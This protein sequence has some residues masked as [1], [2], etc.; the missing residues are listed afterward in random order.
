MD[1]LPTICAHN[2]GFPRIGRSRE[3]KWALEAYW[4]GE[5]DRDELERRGRALR[6]R[7]WEL[8]RAAGLD[9]VPVGDF[10]WYDQVL[11]LTA[12]LGVIP[13]R[14]GWDGGAVD[15]D[16][17]FRLARGQKA[18]RGNIHPL[19]ML[20]WFNTN[21]HY[22]VPEFNSQTSFSLRDRRTKSGN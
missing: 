4:R 3:L 10:S 11:D 20:K 15:L 12:L 18:S 6:R 19:S 16:L 9:L 21:Y 5:I 2:L 8:Q 7:H 14:F 1:A 17:Y 22:L 13:A